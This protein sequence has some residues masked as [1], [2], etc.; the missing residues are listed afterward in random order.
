MNQAAYSRALKILLTRPHFEAELRNKLRA[1]NISEEDIEPIL[2]DLKNRKYINDA[3]Q[4]ELYVAELS[5]KGFGPYHVVNKLV[6]K[7][8]DVDGA[9]SIVEKLFPREMEKESL[10]KLIEKKKIELKKNMD[11]AERKKVFDSLC[12]KGFSSELVR[13]I[14]KF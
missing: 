9:Q 1:R 13:E 11:I 5:R 2:L 10:M 3:E 8:F 6:Q 4:A 12:R 7:G 14:M